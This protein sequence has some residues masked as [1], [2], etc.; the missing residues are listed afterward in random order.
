MA[1]QGSDVRPRAGPNSRVTPVDQWPSTG[2]GTYGASS[3]CISSALSSSCSAA[4]ASSRWPSLVAPTIGAVTPGRCSSHASA[5]WA[6]AHPALAG[7]L[8][9]AIDDVEVAFAVQVVRERVGLRAGGVLLAVTGA[10]PGEHAAGERAPR[11]HADPL[12]DALRDHLPLLLA[13]EEVVV[14]LHRDELAPAVPVRPRAAPSRTATRACCWPRCT[15]PCPTRT[16]SLSASIVSSIG[17][18]GS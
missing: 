16:T 18:F 17:T 3:R 15:A 2:C 8:R 11:D 5:T 10:V 14:V 12:V 6:G 9:D 4:I 7:D 1:D 13:V